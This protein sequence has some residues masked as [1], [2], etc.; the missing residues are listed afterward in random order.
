M[1]TGIRKIQGEAG[2]SLL[3]GLLAA[4]ILVIA[5][6]GLLS[7]MMSASRLD[8]LSKQEVIASNAA[9]QMMETLRNYS[10]FS[11]IYKSY[12][13]LASDD[14]LGAGTAPGGNFA[15]AGLSA[16]T[17][18]ADGFCGEILFPESSPGTLREDITDTTCG[19]PMDL[20]GNGALDAANHASDYTLL[21]VA[22]RVA[23]TAGGRN[24]NHTM[25]MVLSY[26]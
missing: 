12:N 6:M 4:V 15:V 1:K 9:R 22:V 19:T 18:D 2:F 20:D 5:L 13:G 25:R 8:Q 7:A 23:W 17:S 3:E 26:R 11:Y 14:P 21:P 10:D 24:L 16:Q